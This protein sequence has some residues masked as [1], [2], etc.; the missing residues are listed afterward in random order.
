MPQEP[1]K[2]HSRQRKGKRRASIKLEAKKGI[3][4]PNCGKPTLPHVVCKACG[5]YKGKQIIKKPAK[6]P[7]KKDTKE[8]KEAK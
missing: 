4:C 6:K 3:L 8:P 5:Y 2:R 1:K 7:A